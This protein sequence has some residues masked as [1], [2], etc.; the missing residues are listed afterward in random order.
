MRCKYADPWKAQ[1][2]I[3][4]G[5]LVLGSLVLPDLLAAQNRGKTKILNRGR[6]NFEP[7]VVV[8]ED[9]TFV[10]LKFSSR[11]V[12]TGEVRFTG[13]GFGRRSI[14]TPP[15]KM[16]GLGFISPTVHTQPVKM[17]GLLTSRVEVFTEGIKMTGMRGAKREKV[18]IRP[19]RRSGSR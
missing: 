10:G 19:I 2:L 14:E 9:V 11:E 16:K 15:L 4:I 6:A 7:S 1:L 5:I 3:A 8:T 12:R 13:L 18:G 17:T